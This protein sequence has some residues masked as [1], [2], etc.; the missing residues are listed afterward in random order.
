MDSSSLSYQGYKIEIK[1][2]VAETNV[3]SVDIL[4][5]AEHE[6]NFV[7]GNGFEGKR[8]LSRGIGKTN[9][10]YNHIRHD[11]MYSSGFVEHEYA[12]E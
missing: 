5:F 4:L 3:L 7:D 1:Y 10:S 12:A 9:I 6:M 11:G 8:I 2:R